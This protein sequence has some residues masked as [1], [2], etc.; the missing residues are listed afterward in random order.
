M[1]VMKLIV[2]I[3]YNDYIRKAFDCK[4][5]EH[6]CIQLINNNNDINATCINMNRT[7][8]GIIDCIGGT[9]ERLTNICTRKISN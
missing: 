1:D 2:R 7:G 4:S 6:Y 5:N 3:Q 8:D 9:D